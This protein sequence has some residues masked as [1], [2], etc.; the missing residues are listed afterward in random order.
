MN[1]R[2]KTM[3]QHSNY[4]HIR[5]LQVDMILKI[6]KGE[7]LLSLRNDIFQN[8]NKVVNII[9]LNISFQNNIL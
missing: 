8:C 4:L 5:Q 2:E 1:G 3:Y 9:Q 7:L 6:Q